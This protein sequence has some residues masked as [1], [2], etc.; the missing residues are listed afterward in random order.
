MNKKNI[1]SF[2]VAAAKRISVL[3]ELN[4]ELLENSKIASANNKYEYL[5]A[6]DNN[7][8]KIREYQKHIKS[9]DQ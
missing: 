4:E 6:I 7:L 5:D 1:G 9:L 2:Q 8:R 3:L